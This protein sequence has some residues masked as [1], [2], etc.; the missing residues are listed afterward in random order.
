MHSLRCSSYGSLSKSIQNYHSVVMAT[1]TMTTGII[2]AK[3]DWREADRLYSVYTSDFGKLELIGRGAR[4]PLAKLSPHLEFACVADFLVVHGKTMDTLASVERRQA[5]PG[6]YQDYVKTLLLH[7]ALILLDKSIRARQKDS[8]LFSFLHDWLIFLDTAPPLSHERAGFLFSVFALKLLSIFGHKPELTNCLSCTTPIGAGEYR[9][10]ALR[11]GVVCLPCTQKE[12]DQW[13]AAREVDDDS[14][15]LLRFALD[16][17][18]TDQ[19]R[20]RLSGRVIASF[21]DCVESLLISHFPI[22]PAISLRAAMASSNESFDKVEER[23]E[24]L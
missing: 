2:L 6:I 17:T 19:L 10:H 16:N 9:W 24:I 23:A 13:F 7:Q 4:K 20:P 22:I 18:F 1:L 5:F 3:R 8:I 14:L 12:A 21:H 11:G 15:K